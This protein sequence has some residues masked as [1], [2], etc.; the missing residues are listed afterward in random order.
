MKKSRFGVRIGCGPA[1]DAQAVR[2]LRKSLRHIGAA[3]VSGNPTHVVETAS[4]RIEV[5]GQIPAPD[6]RS[7]D[8]SHT[9]LL[10]DRRARNRALPVGMA[11][12]PDCPVRSSTHRGE[13]NISRD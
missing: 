4:G 5:Q 2:R 7:Q 12:V 1:R 11:P 8:V 13:A 10:P 9:H 3:P 6:A